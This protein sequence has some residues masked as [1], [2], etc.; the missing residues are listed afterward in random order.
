MGFK[1]RKS[2]KILPGV[3]LNFSKKGMGISFGGKH[4][5]YSISPTGRR[6][7]SVKIA[8]GLTYSTSSGG[9]KRQRKRHSRA[10]AGYSYSRPQK[11][12]KPSNAL[13]ITVFFLSFFLL[14]ILGIELSWNAMFLKVISILIAILF[15]AFMLVNNIE[16]LKNKILDITGLNKKQKA[17][18]LQLQKILIENSP[19]ELLYG[20]NE[21]LQ[22]V[23]SEA[24]NRLRIFKG[25]ILII[26]KTT[27][28]DTFFSRYDLLLKQAERIDILSD[29]VKFNGVEP[30]SVYQEALNNKQKQIYQMIN[31]YWS[32]TIKGADN[33]KTTNGKKNCYQMFY[34]TLE[35]YKNEISEENIRYYTD[36]YQSAVSCLK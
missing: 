1:F 4:A 11:Q 29:Y 18:L 17:E 6:T 8:P 7:A 35:Q 20:K 32:E 2:K 27:D 15:I 3:R 26:I 13:A 24:S 33:L 31:R 28:P 30:K 5:R 36:K 21:L 9:R 12:V 14:W 10:Q 16:P 19:D 23:Q 22:M 34:D 25:S